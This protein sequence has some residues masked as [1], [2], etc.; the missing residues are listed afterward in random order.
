MI[1]KIL[2]WRM[3][4]GYDVVDPEV[5]PPLQLGQELEVDTWCWDALGV[6][7]WDMVYLS[8]PHHRQPGQSSRSS[9]QLSLRYIT[10]F[11]QAQSSRRLLTPL[12]S[13]QSIN[14]ERA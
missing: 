14:L 3:G 9:Y 6:L 5:L 7:C 11:S 8:F 1:R 2:V 4:W 13:A 10:P 12:A